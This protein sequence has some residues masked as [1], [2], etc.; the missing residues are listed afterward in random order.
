MTVLRNQTIAIYVINLDRSFDR[1][2]QITASLIAQQLSYE[3]IKAVDGQMA[4]HEQLLKLDESEYKKLHG[5]TP[6]P[7]ELGCYLSHL[8]AIQ[9]FAVSS[10]PFAV[11]LE[12]DAIIHDNFGEVINKL[13][14]CSEAWD[15]VKLS[16]IHSGSLA[17]V[18]SVDVNH[19]LCV[20]FTRCT[21]ASAYIINKRAAKAYLQHL[22]PM[23]LPFDHEFDK[24]WKYKLQVL[25]VKPFPVTHNEIITTTICT[26]SRVSRKLPAYKRL[27]TYKYRLNNELARFIY[28]LFLVI[29][30]KVKLFT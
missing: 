19:D 1:L 11:I 12:D 21:G 17:R 8:A 13:T 7:G 18:I 26:P 28:A 9:Q 2:A 27:S 3:R 30:V 25:A 10:K 5:K 6:V 16:G 4:T 23:A 15:M 29:K 22:L 14:T 24:G 20:M